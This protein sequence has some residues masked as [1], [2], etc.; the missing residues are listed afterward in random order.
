MLATSHLLFGA[1]LGT[2]IPDPT[3]AFVV[4]VGSHYLLDALPHVEPG[5][6]RRRDNN[7][8]LRPEL[9]RFEY[10]LAGADVIFGLSIT[11]FI[12]TAHTH[13][14][15]LLTGA[16]GGLLPDILDNVPWW[17]QLVWK[18]PWLHRLAKFHKTIHFPTIPEKRWW[19]GIPAPL[20]ILVF[21][22]ARLFV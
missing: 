15:P 10:W 5:L 17:N 2:L 14:L 21:S 8:N 20:I 3:V 7:G 1:A 4:G 12:W 16:L 6:F 9:E 22:V 13:S 19:W 18:V 11:F